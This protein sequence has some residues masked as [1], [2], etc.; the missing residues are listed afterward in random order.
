[1]DSS[2][3]IPTPSNTPLAR[4]TRAFDQLVSDQWTDFEKK[5]YG[6][7]ERKSKGV[8]K[9]PLDLLTDP[10][11]QSVMKISIFDNDPQ[12]LRTKREVVSQQLGSFAEGVANAFTAGKRQ[13]CQR[14]QTSDKMRQV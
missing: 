10:S 12:Y 2:N 7:S 5:L 1:M 14:H 9:Y 8:Y 4:G 6:E 11:H 3:F 13:N